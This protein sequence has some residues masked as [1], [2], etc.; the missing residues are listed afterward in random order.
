MWM[1]CQLVEEPMGERVP[2]A[3]T[4]NHDF[5]LLEVGV[6]KSIYQ[7]HGVTTANMR[8]E[9]GKVETLLT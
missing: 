7:A 6:P 9:T 5:R 4:S 2:R 3:A 1:P 8:P